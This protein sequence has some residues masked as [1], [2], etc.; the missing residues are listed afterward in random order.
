MSDDMDICGYEDT[1][2]GY[3]CQNPATDG[4]SC[5]LEGHGGN[6]DHP[7]GGRP[8]GSTKLANMEEAE[9]HELMENV[10]NVIEQGGSIAEA[11]RKSGV[12]RETISTWMEIGE[13]KPEGEIHREFF[14]RLVRARGAGEGNYRS[15][16]FRIAVEAEDTATIMAMLKQRYPETWGEVNRGEQA[17][18]VVVNLGEEEEYE[19]DPDTLE[20]TP[21]PEPE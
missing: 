19:V 21:E 14:D 4:D 7:G 15:V 16:L 13:E 1:D 9:A 8:K 18:G 10:A 3:P 20:V 2:R 6:V 11:A 17:G 5:W 12:H